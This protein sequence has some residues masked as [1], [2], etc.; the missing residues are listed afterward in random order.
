MLCD[1]KFNL[2][3]A[4]EEAIKPCLASMT[5]IR[6]F[7]QQHGLTHRLHA[8]LWLFKTYVIPA[9]MYA[10]QIWATSYLHQGQEMENCIQKWLLRFL[11]TILG[12]RNSTPSWSVLR[13]CGL[14]PMQ[15]NWLRACARLY[16]N[17]IFCNSPLLRKVFQ[18]DILLSQFHPACWIS[19]LLLGTQGLRHTPSYH[20]HILNGSP[21]NLSQLIIDLRKR[22]LAFW[23]QPFFTARQPREPET[24]S[25]TFTYYHWCALPQRDAH[26][27]FSPCRLPKYFHLD[28]PTHI[29]HSVARF[30]LRVHLLRIEQNY[31]NESI[32]PKC[33]LCDAHDDAQDEQHV[34]F[35]CTHPHVCNLR[36]KYAS[37]FNGHALSLSTPESHAAPFL[38]ASHH[39]PPHAMR[40]FLNQNNNKLYPF[41]HELLL[42]YEQASSQSV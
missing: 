17:L 15:L 18:A 26:A 38:H 19:H 7:I 16:N 21:L 20:H 23:Q 13:E 34:L 41:L 25:K 35:K 28:L 22:H 31:W 5:R 42:F 32:D 29:I 39:V 3:K 6:T 8:Y 10:S 27:T 12:V 40:S 4:A 9:G 14:E 36:R 30:R 24:N 2:N 33:D 11:R 1:K 37:L